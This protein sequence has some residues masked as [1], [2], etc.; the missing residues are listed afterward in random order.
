MAQHEGAREVPVLRPL[1]PTVDRLLPYLS[2]IDASRCYTN[3]GP[4]AS[5]LE[6]RLAR[7]F[8]VGDHGVI[9]ASSGTA[10]LVGAI[11]AT[12]GRATPDRPLAILPALTF[13]ATAVAAEQCGYRVHLVDVAP[14][15]WMLTARSL[16]ARDLLERTGVVIPVSAY[17]R[18]VVHEPWR[19]FRQETGIPVV[20]DG[21]A[22]FEAIGVDAGR[23]LSEL[24]VTLSFHATKAF[25]SGEGGCVIT[26][27]A[28]LAVS[29]IRSL[30]F[31]FYEDRESRSASTNGKMSEYHAAV[32]LAELDAWPAKQQGFITMADTYRKLI[33]DVGL[34]DRLVTTPEVA[35][36]YVLF[37]G[38]DVHETACVTEALIERNV[39]FRCWY[40]AG[41]H[42][43]PHFRNASRHSLEV[44]ERF[45][46]VLIGLPAAPDL[47]ESDVA[48]VVSALELGVSRSR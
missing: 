6:G 2:R 26:T 27:D 13:V 41:L 44:T 47:P 35:A 5:E 16:H 4:L 7:R 40:G 48:R 15:D 36:C 12:A 9:S 38:A 21:A 8:G 17:G 43:Q 42:C 11:L 18:P 33:N 3:W 19:T 31:G 29:V 34:A 1:L 32:G 23:L 45:A 10:A 22:S 30:N 28:T 25:A 14:D 24:P 46:S 20:I 39:G 37:E